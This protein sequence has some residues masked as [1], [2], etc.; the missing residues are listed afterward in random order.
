MKKKMKIMMMNGSVNLV[1]LQMKD[2]RKKK[3]LDLPCMQLLH[4]MMWLR[5]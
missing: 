4:S 5:K 3:N 2:V 1:L